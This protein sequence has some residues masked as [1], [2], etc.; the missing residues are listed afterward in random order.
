MV[1]MEDDCDLSVVKNWG[2][3]WRQFTRVTYHFTG[4]LFN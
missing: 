3:T 4:T 1:V 2:F